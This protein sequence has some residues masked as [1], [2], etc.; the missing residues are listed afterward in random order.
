M[1]GVMSIDACLAKGELA[2]FGVKIE[3][4]ELF[5]FKK[6]LEE[7]G[8]KRPTYTITLNANVGGVRLCIVRNGYIKSKIG[9]IPMLSRS[10]MECALEKASGVSLLE[11]Y[12]CKDIRKIVYQYRDE[13]CSYSADKNY[14]E[15]MHVAQLDEDDKEE[16]TSL[17]EDKVKARLRPFRLA[18]NDLIRVLKGREEF[19][20]AECY[21]D[22]VKADRVAFLSRSFY[23]IED[24]A[25]F[26]LPAKP[27]IYGK[28]INEYSDFEE[29][30]LLKKNGTKGYL[31]YYYALGFGLSA[32]RLSKFSLIAEDEN[33]NNMLFSWSTSQLSSIVSHAFCVDKEATRQV[34]SEKGLP[35][36]AGRAFEPKDVQSALDYADLIG[37]PLVCK[38]LNGSKGEGVVVNIRTQDELLNAINT[39]GRSVYKDSDFIVEKFIKGKDYRVVVVGDEVKGALCRELASVTGDGVHS[40]ADLMLA[41]HAWRMRNPHFID[42][43]AFIEEDNAFGNI[44]DHSIDLLRVPSLGEHVVFGTSCNLSQGADSVDVLDELHPSIKEAA[45]RATKAVPGLRYCGVDILIEDHTKE[46][47]SQSAAIIELNAKAAIGNCEYPMFGKPREVVKSIFTNVAHDFDIKVSEQF[48]DGRCKVLCEVKGALDKEDYLR[49]ARRSARQLGVSYSA[50]DA[51]PSRVSIEIDGSVKSVSMMA[52]RLIV[53]PTSSRPSSV[54]ARLLA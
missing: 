45:V 11:D 28:E 9:R 37:Y 24:Y 17:L 31:F 44:N 19:S 41:K 22:G 26:P 21:V 30:K 15:L 8:E 14:D 38:P 25:V 42:R 29:L 35:V 7:V 23:R 1:D 33:R 49:W 54:K 13:V 53:G 20:K 47:S 50:Q 2:E 12:R 10:M 16:S 32:T 48:N 18:I 34:L 39:L 3:S 6:Q 4:C 46:I 51:G 36:P 43:S 52:T 40:M 5:L 27:F